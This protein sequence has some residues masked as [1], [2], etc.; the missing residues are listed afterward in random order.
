[1]YLHNGCKLQRV[2]T[3]E[4]GSVLINYEE[5][6]VSMK[7]E[8]KNKARAAQYEVGQGDCRGG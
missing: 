4:T 7:S 2:R 5:A 6:F 8:L 1:M 3:E